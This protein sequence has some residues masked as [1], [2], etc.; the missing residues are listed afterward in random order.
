[1][2]ATELPTFVLLLLLLPSL[3]LGF[4]MA[5]IDLGGQEVHGGSTQFEVALILIC[6]SI[7]FYMQ[8]RY[9]IFVASHIHGRESKHAV[10]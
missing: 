2:R 5:A 8:L 10:F 1:M 7:I 6:I 4:Y 3:L 9:Y